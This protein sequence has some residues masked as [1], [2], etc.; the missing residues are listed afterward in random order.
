VK[1]PCHR[2][3]LIGLYVKSPCH[4]YSTAHVV[5]ALLVL[6]MVAACGYTFLVSTLHNA[7]IETKVAHKITIV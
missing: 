6:L 1:G 3:M 2:Y 7:V 4:R 5:C